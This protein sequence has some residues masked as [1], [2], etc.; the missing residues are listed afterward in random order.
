VSVCITVTLLDGLVLAR[1]VYNTDMRFRSVCALGTAHL[2][3]SASV[4]LGVISF[5]LPWPFRTCPHHGLLLSR[6]REIS[7]VGAI[8]SSL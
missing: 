6:L 7:W 4:E 1:S 2:V 8:L 3:V 5:V